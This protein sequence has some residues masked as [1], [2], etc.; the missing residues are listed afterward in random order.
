MTTKEMTATEIK[1]AIG[2][3]L[4]PEAL[5]YWDGC[6]GEQINEYVVMAQRESLQVAINEIEA[7]VN[8]SP[9]LA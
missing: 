8:E 6:G 4:S 7:W 5:S 1:N 2:N 3:S 9:E